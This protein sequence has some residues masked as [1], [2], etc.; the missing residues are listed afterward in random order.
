MMGYVLNSFLR[1]KGRLFEQVALTIGVGILINYCLMLTGQTI[2]RV[3]IAGMIL[4]L[5]G[6]LRF[7]TDLRIR[8]ANGISEY[9]AAVFSVCCII[10]ILAVYYL[11]IFSEPLLHWDARSIWFFHARMI[12]TEGA[13]RQ[14]TGWNHP[15]LVFSHPD[16]PKLVPAIA[17]QLAHVKGYWNEFLPKGS[18]LVLLV[19]LLL[20]VFS[21]RQKRL[22]FILLVLM[23]FFSLDAWLSNGYMDGYLAVYCGVALLLFGRYLY[24][25]R[26]TDLYSGMCTL[27]I[28]A[29]IKN[30]GLLFGLCLITALLL[31]SP[32]YP[33]FSFRQ[34]TKRIRTDS[35]FAKVLILSLA[36]T[37]MW[38]ICK[39]AWGL[40]N[41]LTGDPSAGLSRLSN[42]LFDGFSAQYVL[43][44]LTVRATAI[45]VVIGLFLITVMFSVHQGVKLHRGALVAATTAA[46]YLCGLYVAYLSTPLDLTF[47]LFT[48][49]T[50][51]M[52]T[53]SVGLFVS[54]FFLLSSLEVNEGAR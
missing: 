28:G 41:D 21:F 26:D 11:E 15:S 34:C 17:A 37:L 43:N 22:S 44:Y 36:P 29:S 45:W 8:P 6:V 25:R 18:L 32:A 42:R 46:L 30:E 47:H 33:E 52:A 13:L 50:R 2:T 23:F 10:Y 51:T 9:K 12:W 19:P 3:F 16:Y 31:I 5:W 38:T 40:Q 4:A 49:A 39:K 35:L 20:W 14:Q 1:G 53:A 54:M 7:S 48:S 27:G 24:E